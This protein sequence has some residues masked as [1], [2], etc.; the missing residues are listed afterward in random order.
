MQSMS[1]QKLLQSSKVPSA[2]G[3]VVTDKQS[4]I[5]G[6]LANGKTTKLNTVTGKNGEVT[7]GQEGEKGEKGEIDFSSLF[8]VAKGEIG[9]SANSKN[10]VKKENVLTGKI[11]STKSSLDKLLNSLK[12]T[13]DVQVDDSVE[14][15]ESDPQS[16]NLIKKDFFPHLN[17]DSQSPLEFLMKNTKE[18][19]ITSVDSPVDESGEKVDLKLLLEKGNSPKTTNIKN[20]LFANKITNPSIAEKSDNQEKTVRVLSGEDFVNNL[21]AANSPL[22]MERGSGIEKL[23]LVDKEASLE[24]KSLGMLGQNIPQINNYGKGQNLLNDSMIR[25]TKDLAFKDTKKL[26][27]EATDELKSPELKISN[28]LSMIKESPL[29]GLQ[30]KNSFVEENK[31]QVES[32]VLNLSN[33]DAKNT[34]EIIKTISDYVEQNQVANKSSMDLIVKHDSLGQFQIQVSKN[35]NQNQVDMQI[36]TSSAEGHKFFV[37]HEADLMKNLQNAGVNLSDLRIISSMK[38]STPF[39]QSESK[40]FSSFQ[41]EQNG[42]SKQFMSFESGDFRDGAQKRKSLW[43]EYQ[44]RYGA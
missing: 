2:K 6:M 12:G 35:N 14:N 17:K 37:A 27:I 33:I 24:K 11:A 18:K 34:N 30:L 15:T 7:E 25:N 44:E 29:A 28:E 41:H 19:N 13:E 26:K 40:Q 22:K 39:S 8:T 9:N 4:V 3:D 20:E 23:T 1:V 31:T 38:E 21:K 42:D 10:A 43:E 16:K 36:T 32:K 5:E